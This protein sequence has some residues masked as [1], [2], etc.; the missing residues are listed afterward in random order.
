MQPP[1]YQI[2]PDEIAGLLSTAKW[3]IGGVAAVIGTAIGFLMHLAYRFG[4]HVKELKNVAENMMGIKA[5]ADE[6]PPLKVR[7]GNVERY[8]EHV[9]SKVSR[10]DS[11]IK[12]ILRGSNP[13]F[14][15]GD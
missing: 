15:G 13:N 12:S 3:L 6:V 9:E 10:H 2:T 8:I 11:D 7:I 1:S 14:N 5:N 4:G